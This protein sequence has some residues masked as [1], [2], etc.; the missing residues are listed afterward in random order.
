MEISPRRLVFIIR[1]IFLK[2][3][4]KERFGFFAILTITF[5]S[6]LHLQVSYRSQFRA[7]AESW[8]LRQQNWTLPRNAYNWECSPMVLPSGFLDIVF[9]PERFRRFLEYRHCQTFPQIIDEPRKCHMPGRQKNTVLLLSVKTLP[10]HYKRRKVIRETWGKEMVIGG[11]E[12]RTLFL[13][14]LPSNN[15]GASELQ[16]MVQVES[17]VYKDIVQWGFV[18]TFFNLTLKQVSFMRWVSSNCPE[19]MFIFNGDDDVFVNI[20]NVVKM[21]TF[22]PMSDLYLGNVFSSGHRRFIWW[23]KYYIP[24]W[25][26]DKSIY[27]PYVGGAGILMSA[28]TVRKFYKAVSFV[29]LYPIDDVYIG[30]L[31]EK[32]GVV[33]IPHSGFKSLGY[34][35]WLDA[36]KMTKSECLVK[37]LLVTHQFLPE[38][39]TKLWNSLESQ[40]YKC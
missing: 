7:L 35:S 19:A 33:A 17:A 34:Y 3:K 13:I 5:L 4:R 12:V 21:L 6:Y 31:A 40:S 30:M 22:N 2:V 24:W 38:E 1:L 15:N 10:E 32:S 8:R 26:Y 11:V 37:D 36:L 28:A 23:S 27:P 20:K 14:G 29:D 16:K 18:D 9:M 25:M 39:L